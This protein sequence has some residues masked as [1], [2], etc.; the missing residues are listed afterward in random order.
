MAGNKKFKRAAEDDDT[1]GRVLIS[2][3]VVLDLLPDMLPTATFSSGI[4]RKRETGR[5]RW[6]ADGRQKKE[7]EKKRN[8]G[9]APSP[10]RTPPP[11]SA[12]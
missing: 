1:A 12:R 8:G 4:L 11:F 9:K 3:L 2:H 10:T 7:K 5:S 6:T